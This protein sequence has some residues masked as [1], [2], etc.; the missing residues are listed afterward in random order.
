MS[1]PVLVTDRTAWPSS[2]FP[3]AE[4]YFGFGGYP[5]GLF[6]PSLPSQ[7]TDVAAVLPA[8]VSPANPSIVAV[9]YPSDTLRAAVAAKGAYNGHRF[10]VP[11][12]LDKPS[13]R[14]RH[15]HASKWPVRAV[16]GGQRWCR[17]LPPRSRWP[18]RHK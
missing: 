3:V 17:Y 5:T 13:S 18:H 15:C 9:S 6:L 4:Q 14:L 7:V 11:R 12:R 8:T 16:T 1:G 10:F 2:G